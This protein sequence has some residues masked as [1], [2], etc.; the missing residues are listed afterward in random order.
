VFAG[1]DAEK[2]TQKLYTEWGWWRG[3]IRI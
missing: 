1:K 3:K 2:L